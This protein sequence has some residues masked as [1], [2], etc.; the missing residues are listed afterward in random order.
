MK[1]RFQGVGP[2][3]CM[4]WGRDFDVPQQA[5]ATEEQAVK[6]ALACCEE[7]DQRD[8]SVIELDH[9]FEEAIA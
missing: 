6:A 4:Q 2:Y 5:F 7:V 3:L 9:C 8:E 1:Y